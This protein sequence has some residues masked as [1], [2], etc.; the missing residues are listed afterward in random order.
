MRRILALLVTLLVPVP[1]AAQSEAAPSAEKIFEALAVREGGTAC[2]VGAG[3]GTLS[4]AAAKAVGTSGRV[5]T[6][7]LGEGRVEKL[8]AAVGASGLAHIT[9]V[10]GDAEKTNFPDA[11]CDA[12]FMRDVYHHFTSPARMNVAIHAAL[13]PGGRVAIVDFTPPGEEA[14]PR[15]APQTACTVSFPKRSSGK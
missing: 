13:K 6:S 15:T 12:L 10:A 14:A 7:E 3:I 4:I 2:E 11:V 5:F 1:V 8:R 9:V